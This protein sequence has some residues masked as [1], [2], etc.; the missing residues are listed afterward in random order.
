MLMGLVHGRRQM[1]PNGTPDA[2]F[3][4]WTGQDYEWSESEFSWSRSGIHNLGTDSTLVIRHVPVYVIFRSI[5]KGN[6][7]QWLM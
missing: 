3:Q 4:A 7:V 1:V 2:P 5:L 6:L